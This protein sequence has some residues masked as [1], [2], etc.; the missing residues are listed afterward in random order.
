MINASIIFGVIT[1][2]ATIIAGKLITA[3]LVLF[4]GF[5]LTKLI[6]KNISRCHAFSKLDKSVQSFAKSAISIGLKVLIIITAAG[7]LG[8]QMASFITILGS[9]AVAVGLSLQGSLSNIAGGIL[10]LILK[11]FGVGDFITAGANSGT[12]T[13]IGMFYTYLESEDKKR[14]IIPN[15]SI[16]NQPVIN[17][18]VK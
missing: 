1:Q 16:T 8:I 5:K 11:P 13:E 6:V 2:Y 17:S 15:S 12:V 7:M 10:I 14:I 18:S 3:L 4:I 9:V